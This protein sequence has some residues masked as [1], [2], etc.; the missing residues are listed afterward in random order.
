MKWVAYKS[1]QLHTSVYA[2]K[3]HSSDIGF[4]IP[5]ILENL[6]YGLE[7]GILHRITAYKNALSSIL[8]PPESLLKPFKRQR[9]NNSRLNTYPLTI[10]VFLGLFVL[11]SRPDVRDRSDRC[12]TDVRQKHRLM[13]PPIRGGGIIITI[14]ATKSLLS[15][16]MIRMDNSLSA[17]YRS[18]VI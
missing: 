7:A 17:L 5:N 2:A 18:A 16:P 12:Q 11:E 1:L 13:P 6:A 9:Q 3:R 15:L 4:N 10:L 8:S 14:W